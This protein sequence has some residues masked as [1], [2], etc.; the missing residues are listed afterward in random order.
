MRPYKVVIDGVTMGT[1]GNGETKVFDVDAGHHE[2]RLKIDWTGSQA[3][4][5]DAQTGEVVTFEC[6]PD[7]TSLTVMME[8]VVS[9]FGKQGRPWIDLRRT[10]NEAPR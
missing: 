9:L 1:I 10:D 8:L 3:V 5:F 4:R 6:Q 7:G 2:V